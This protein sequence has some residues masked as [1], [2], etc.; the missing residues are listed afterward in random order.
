MIMALASALCVTRA[1]HSRDSNAAIMPLNYSAGLSAQRIISLVSRSYHASQLPTHRNLTNQFH[2]NITDASLLRELTQ[3]SRIRIWGHSRIH[4]F[5]RNLFHV[6]LSEVKLVFDASIA[7]RAR[8]VS[9]PRWQR[10]C[11]SIMRAMRLGCPEHE[12]H[13]E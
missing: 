5:F 6:R 3:I 11:T 10:P 13:I 7:P 4:P 12:L 8:P 9:S 2:K 1:R